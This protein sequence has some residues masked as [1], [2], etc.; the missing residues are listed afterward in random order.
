MDRQH[1]HQLKH[2]KFVDNV[3]VLSSRAREN[4]RLLILV[5]GGLLAVSAIVYGLFTYRSN[6]ETEAQLMLGTAIETYD[7]PIKGEQQQ[8][9]V[10]SGPSFKTEQERNAAAEKQFKDVQQKYSG[11]DAADVAGLYLGQIAVS[12]GDTA[13]ARGLFQKFIGDHKDNIL[14]S[15]ARFSLYQMRIGSGEA[16]QVTAELNAEL[17]KPTPVLPGDAILVLLAQAYEQQGNAA[18]S[19]EAYRRIATEYPDS[20]YVVEAQRRAGAA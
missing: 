20:A 15:T 19:K 5:A 7:A 12:R 1:R 8:K 14:V 9:Q 6:R 13:T 10:E 11:T 17:A 16:A 18:K 3:G 4:Q 2:D